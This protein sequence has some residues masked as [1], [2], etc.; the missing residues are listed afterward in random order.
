MLALSLWT[1]SVVT[2]AAD[3]AIIP[4]PQSLEPQD[5]VFTL[6]SGAR[7]YTDPV[8]T[9]TGVYLADH[10]R[11]STGYRLKVSSKLVPDVATV[12]GIV[13]TTQNADASLGAVMN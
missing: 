11:P 5:G 8:S 2:G 7:I 4:Q 3:L 10:L 13:L 9:D 1:A 6:T 12:S